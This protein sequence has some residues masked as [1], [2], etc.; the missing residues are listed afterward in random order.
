MIR[1]PGSGINP[2]GTFVGDDDD[3]EDEDD[4]NE[5]DEGGTTAALLFVDTE[6]RLLFGFGY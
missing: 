3:E 4:D 1:P 6:L 5:I 2:T